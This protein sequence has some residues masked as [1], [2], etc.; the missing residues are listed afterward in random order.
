MENPTNIRPKLR[1]DVAF[2]LTNEGLVFLKDGE[3]F[4]VK[5]KAAVA[6]FSRFGSYLDGQYTLAEL[7]E[8][9]EPARLA[10]VVA[11]VNTLL[12]KGILKNIQAETS[13]LIPDTVRE[14]FGS[15]I[16]FISHYSDT[17]QHCFSMFRKSRLLLVGCGEM[18]LALARSLLHNGLQEL[19]LVPIGDVYDYEQRLEAEAR[20]LRERGVEIVL[21]SLACSVLHHSQNLQG[22]DLV[23]CCVESSMLTT[24]FELNKYCL[25]EEIPFLPAVTLGKQAL[26]GPL[27]RPT[28]GPCWLCAL[29]RF[30]SNIEKISSAALW[31]AALCGRDFGEAITPLFTPAER[32]IGNGLGFEAFKI[33]TG[34]VPLETENGVIIQDLETLETGRSLLIRHPLCPVCSCD[35]NSRTRCELQEVVAGKRDCFLVPEELAEREQQFI[36]PHFGICAQFVDSDSTQLPLRQTKLLVGPPTSPLDKHLDVRAYGIEHLREARQTA[37]KEAIKRYARALPDKRSMVIASSDEMEARNEHI[38]EA[39]QFSTWSGSQVTTRNMRIAW[40]PAFAY[41]AQ[42]YCFVPASAIYPETSFNRQG[43]IERNAAGLGVGLTFRDTLADGMLSALAFVHLHGLLRGQGSV[44][45]LDLEILKISDPDLRFLVEI[46]KHL[47]QA[48]TVLEVVHTSPLHVVI[49]YSADPLKTSP[50][51]TIGWGLSANE[52]LKK[53]LLELAGTFQTEE[54]RADTG[55]ALFPAFSPFIEFAHADA[56]ASRFLE[57]GGTLAQIET[58]LHQQHYEILFADTTPPDIYE[59]ATYMS[60]SVL[61]ARLCS[62]ATGA[63]QREERAAEEVE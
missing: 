12:Q 4:R 22:Y 18:L 15:Q 1:S 63:L 27:V 21:S 42:S 33:L 8:G 41:F 53:A 49:V 31:Q 55:V 19:T 44:V 40:Q 16:E 17:P 23:V 26:L 3:S 51:Y 60:G 57:P 59:H 46:L 38:I 52:A 25:K 45:R 10:N 13:V 39:H 9:F 20:L 62:E 6:W 47:E 28:S 61:L 37:F 54:D 14:H 5:N 36:D 48:Y 50:L 56:T 30:S 34:I 29:L 58:H 2:F 24:V 43:I 35:K 32:M 11:L 7:C